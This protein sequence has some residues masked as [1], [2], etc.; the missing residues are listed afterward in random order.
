MAEKEININ[1]YK[2]QYIQHC[3]EAIRREYKGVEG[4][5]LRSAMKQFIE[6]FCY[7]MEENKIKMVQQID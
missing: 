2:D 7:N 1:E 3:E 6:D 4:I 5:A